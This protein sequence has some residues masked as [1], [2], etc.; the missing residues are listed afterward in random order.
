MVYYLFYLSQLARMLCV[1]AFHS[2]L[3]RSLAPLSHLIWAFK[4]ISSN[5]SVNCRTISWESVSMVATSLGT[6]S[7]EGVLIP[8]PRVPPALCVFACNYSIKTSDCMSVNGTFIKYWFGQSIDWSRKRANKWRLRLFIDLCFLCVAPQPGHHETK[9][10]ALT[11]MG[12]VWCYKRN[13]FIIMLQM[14]CVVIDAVKSLPLI[15][16]MHGELHSPCW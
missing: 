8:H 11:T 13:G 2:Y 14:R 7:A 5:Y 1:G 15:D 10:N 3:F 4:A 9:A 6:R 16:C 12:R